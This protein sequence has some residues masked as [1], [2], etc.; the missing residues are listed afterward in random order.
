[1]EEERLI[2]QISEIIYQQ[3]N[4]DMEDIDVYFHK[5]QKDIEKEI[6]YEIEKLSN[7]WKMDYSEEEE[8]AYLSFFFLR[9]S[10]VTESYVM[11]VAFYG[12]NMYFSDKSVSEYWKPYFIFNQ[13]VEGKK[14]VEKKIKQ[15]CLDCSQTLLRGI[16]L[17]YGYLYATLW[18][19]FLQRRIEKIVDS[20]IETK[21]LLTDN[22][23]IT[24][25]ELYGELEVILDLG[26]EDS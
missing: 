17:N 8:I 26:S 22:F 7:K 2:E 3:F 14:K 23:K 11:Y 21:L 15:Q 16:L 12:E 25:G 19:L 18:K 20:L 4:Q 13:Y 1:M 10:I 5:N 24:F 6:Y 9:S